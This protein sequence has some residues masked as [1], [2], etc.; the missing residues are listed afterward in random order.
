MKDQDCWRTV[1][2]PL[3][4]PHAPYHVR[5]RRFWRAFW[6]FAALVVICAT[7][8]GLGYFS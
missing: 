8:A 4:E 2:H 6:W 1:C 3:P 5:R 7:L